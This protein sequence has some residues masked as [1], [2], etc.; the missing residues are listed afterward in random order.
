MER[1]RIVTGA[2][3][4]LELQALARS[5]LIAEPARHYL[6]AVIRASR[7][8]DFVIPDDIKALAVPVL[9]HRIIPKT[10]TRLKGCTEED[11]LREV[12]DT[13]PVP[14]EKRRL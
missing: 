14:A 1:L 5:T 7:G 10:E 4:L 9:S 11:L 2:A 6:L 3:E 12:L 8:R 13:V